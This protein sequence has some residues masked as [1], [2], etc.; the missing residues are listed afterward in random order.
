MTNTIKLKR[1]S[2]SDPSA[3]DMVVGEPVLRSDTAEL[4]FKKDDGSVAKVSGGGSGGSSFQY[5]ALR[6]AANDGAASYPGNDFT[7]VTSGTT[8]AVSPA[9]ANALILSYGG[10][11][12]K[13]NSGTSTSGITGFIVDGSR[14][15]TA[16]NFAAA[17]D[18]IVYQESGGIGEPSD[19]TVTEAKLNASNSPTN[20]YFLQAQSGVTGGLTWAA[21]P[22]N[23]S[24]TGIDF[25]DNVKARW[26]TGN[27]LEIFHDGSHS[28]IDNVATGDLFIRSTQTNGDVNIVCSASNGGFVVK[29]TTPETIIN[30]VANGAVSLYYDNSKKLETAS[31]KVMFSAHAKVAAN[32]TYDLGASG[33]RW[34]D[35]YISND[36][37]ISDNGKI[38]LGTGDD[39]QLYHD[40][41]TNY[42]YS[43]NGHIVAR[44]PT[45][46]GFRVQKNDGQED[47]LNAFADGAVELYYDGSKKLETTAVGVKVLGAEASNAN[48]E[49]YADEGD[50]AADKWN[51]YAAAVGNFG[52]NNFASGAWEQNIECNPNG[53]VELY[54]DNSKK[55]ETTST[56]ATITGNFVPESNDTWALGTGSLRWAGA[57]ITALR[58]YTDGQWYDNAKATFGHGE[59]LQIYHDGNNN[60]I[61][62]SPTVLIKNKANSES[63]IR[64]NEN[65]EVKLYYNGGGTM[66]TTQYGIEIYDELN[67]YHQ[68]G[69]SYIKN[70]TGN[71]HIGTNGGTYIYGGNDFG[72][73]CATFLNDGATN[74]YYDHSK[75]LNTESWGVQVTGTLQCS[76]H[77]NLGDGD[78]LKIGDGEDLLIYHDSANSVIV[79]STGNLYQRTTGNL[80]LQVNGGSNENAILAQTNASVSLYYDNSKKLETTTNG[81]YLTG[82]IRFNNSGW[83]GETSN[84]KIQTHSS[85]MYLQAAG[86]SWNFR[87]TSGTNV[88]SISNSGTYSSSDER[89]KKDITTIT[90]AVN[91]IKQLTGRSFTWKEDD[92]KSFGVIAQEV[93]PV[94][95]DL[96]VTQLL[97]DGE[98]NS[99]PLKSVNYA[100]LTGHFIEA[101]KELTTKIET[102]ETKVAALEGS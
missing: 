54:Y 50:D 86:G 21:A 93:E 1:G 59:D 56:G 97:I 58:I 29:S 89:R 71:L 32:D 64:C 87:T 77:I 23:D 74:L 46:K 30:A 18:F 3:S 44:V 102:L 25:D 73:Y 57:H 63:Y 90:G 79:N 55:L 99:D 80:Y 19:N 95:P 88:A 78:E 48:L 43:G 94:L 16:T 60:L 15:K 34:K 51:I 52:I 26:G 68:S 61:L 70:D 83:T 84:G 53:N 66:A 49:M 31:D 28:Y 37:D 41:S 35:L 92:K 91:T 72:E 40:G 27:D 9:T 42:L 12:Q 10:V 85:H 45:T 75:K 101:I 7:L 4:F 2:G 5:L 14:L 24:S 62:G 17:P 13:P 38:L 98:T 81:I 6:N 65:A 8:T 20:G 36:I 11:V 100:A 96:V 22:A 76:S 69:N 33:A 82:D 39:L 67:L 47:V